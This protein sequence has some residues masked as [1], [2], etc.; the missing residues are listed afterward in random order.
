MILDHAE[1]L[2]QYVNILPYDKWPAELNARTNCLAFQLGLAIDL[3]KDYLELGKLFNT[4]TSVDDHNAFLETYGQLLT[5]LGFEWRKILRVD[6]ANIDE[7]IF[8]MYGPFHFDDYPYYNFHAIR[9]ELDGTWVHKTT[10]G[11]YPSI[12]EWKHFSVAY[13]K[14]TILGTYAVKRKTP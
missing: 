4:R 6:D 1:K 9:R 5:R 2:R 10:F 11:S 13:P 8:Q 14:T 7:Y 3:G 12:I